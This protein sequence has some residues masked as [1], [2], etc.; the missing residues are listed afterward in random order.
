M[1]ISTS[2]AQTAPQG[3]NESRQGLWRLTLRPAGI[4]ATGHPFDAWRCMA[5]EDHALFDRPE[6]AARAD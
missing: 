2:R 3:G 5:A 4:C 1:T 6:P